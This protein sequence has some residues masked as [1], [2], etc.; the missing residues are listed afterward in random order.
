MAVKLFFCY[1]H[2]DEPLLN[3]LKLRFLHFCEVVK[4]LD[5]TIPEREPKHAENDLHPGV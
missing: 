5:E 4:I 3:K 1:S 2:E